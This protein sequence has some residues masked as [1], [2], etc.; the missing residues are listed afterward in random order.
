[1]RRPA[2]DDLPHV[3]HELWWAVVAGAGDLAAYVPRGSRLVCAL[4]DAPAEW[5]AAAAALG[6]GGPG[7]AVVCVTAPG[8]PPPNRP[9]A[10]ETEPRPGTIP[11]PTS[12]YGS[13]PPVRPPPTGKS[14]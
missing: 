7:G 6:D 5:R 9:W 13:V 11:T 3:F 12:T 4:P 1:M 2:S 10:W 14:R 8:V